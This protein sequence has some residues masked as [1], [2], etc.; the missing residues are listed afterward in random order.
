[1]SNGPIPNQ[2]DPRRFADRALTFTG[3]W[4]LDSFERLTGLVSDT[5]G[6]VQVSLA[7]Y[8]DEQE[9]PVMR[10]R[11]DA[12]VGMQCQRCLDQARLSLAGEHSFAF[13]RP[14]DDASLLPQDYDVIELADEPLDVRALAEEELLLALPI[15]P[16][17]PE[18]Q[19]N[20][21]QGYVEPELSE[22]DRI[23]SSPFGVLAQ[24]RKP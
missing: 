1:M 24:L 16:M 21:P 12:E 20:H 15:V 10:M 2:V 3:A 7:F 6:E 14:G 11:L 5:A 13:I 17:H 4:P 18:G 9:L 19:C 22:E 23:R 8:R